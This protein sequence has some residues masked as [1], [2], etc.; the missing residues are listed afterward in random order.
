MSTPASP[1]APAT[2]AADLSHCEAVLFDLD[3][4]LADTAP[5]LAGAVH[6]MQRERGLAETPLELLRPL[7]SA[8][9]RGL[10]G[11]GFGITPE[12]PGYEAMRQEFLANYAGA[13]CVKTVLFPG[14]AELLDELDARGVRWGIV[15]NKAM[16]LTEPLVALLG[17]AARAA[18]VVC[19]DTT[20]HAKPHPA[21]LL[22][23]AAQMGIAPQRIVYVGDDLR[24]IQ[25]GA[26]AG[27]PTIAA[28]YGYCGDGVP[29][30]RW[31]A[32]HFAATTKG[33]RELLRNV[34]L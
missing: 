26:A 2:A 24:D 10:L 7:A 34:A 33:L 14:I 32:Q 30:E 13:L 21:P 28:A 20:P 16:R 25:A 12:A 18:S 22:H 5:D 29:P 3:G 17:L 15:T 6:K 23:A 9:A 1:L 27:M 19:G 4:T 31:Q 11:G 8:G